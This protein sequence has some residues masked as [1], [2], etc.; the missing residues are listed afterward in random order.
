MRCPASL[1][2]LWIITSLLALPVAS[3]ADEMRIEQ[4]V[5]IQHFLEAAKAGDLATVRAHLDEGMPIDV[6]LPL[7]DVRYPYT[8]RTPLEAAA[9][10]ARMNVV[11]FLLERGATLRRHERYGVLAAALHTVDSPELLA[12]LVERAGPD[13]DLDA[14]FGPA[15][16]RAAANAAIGELDYLLALG[17]DPDYRNRFEPWDEPPIVRARMHFDV[18]ER[19]LDAG[20]DPMGGGL[21]DRWS[22]LL[23][24]AEAA[25]AD[26]L[27]RLLDM[28]V[29]PNLRGERGNALSLVACSVPRTVRPGAERRA[30]INEVAELLVAA[31][32]DPNVSSGGRSPLRCAE[33]S[34][35]ADLAAVLTAAGGRSYE[36][37]WVRTK[38]GVG[39]AVMSLVVILGG[40][41]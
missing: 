1:R 41:M 22:P 29:D 24:A 38:R 13:A 12:A 40:G 21:G 34:L 17:V 8:V 3:A 35:N 11:R 37:L 16:V 15:L 7:K 19:L 39:M 23:P 10:Y 9:V 26:M 31:G 27:R 25:N 28:G 4:R 14:D 36:S 6:T 33:D 2:S 20:A 30:R 18:M 5:A 32:V